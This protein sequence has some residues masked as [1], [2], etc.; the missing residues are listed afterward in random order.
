MMGRLAALAAVS[1]GLTLGAEG[2]ATADDRG[3]LDWLAANGYTYGPLTG[4]PSTAL[5]QGNLVC[6]NIRYSG[7][8]RAGFNP[9]SNSITPDYLIEGA[10]RELCPDTLGGAA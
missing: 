9:I 8:A 2:T 1:L 4:T 3:Y 6:N 10:Q 5:L 7:D